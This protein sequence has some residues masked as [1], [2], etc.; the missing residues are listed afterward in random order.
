[1]PGFAA[2]DPRRDVPGWEGVIAA[3]ASTVGRSELVEPAANGATERPIYT[4][5]PAHSSF[6]A[7]WTAVA[8][9]WP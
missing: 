9:R 1:M 6:A 4:A 3:A 8:W 7:F 2:D 5:I